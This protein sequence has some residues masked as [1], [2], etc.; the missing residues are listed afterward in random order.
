MK[1][2]ITR[3][4]E[5]K[6]K[7]KIYRVNGCENNTNIFN[8]NNLQNCFVNGLKIPYVP[9]GAV[10]RDA[11]LLCEAL[12]AFRAAA[13]LAQLVCPGASQAGPEIPGGGRSFWRRNS[14]TRAVGLVS[15][16]SEDIHD[17]R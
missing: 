9:F 5:I 2:R 13:R 16:T 4:T 17:G 10:W 12:K 7:L 15:S 8:I 11:S 1:V 14:R 6:Q 3:C